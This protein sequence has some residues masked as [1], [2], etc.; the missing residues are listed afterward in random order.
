MFRLCTWL[1]VEDTTLDFKCT[2]RR[3]ELKYARYFAVYYDSIQILKTKQQIDQNR[4]V[5]SCCKYV[6][7]P[8]VYNSISE[9]FT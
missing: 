8:H 4:Y 9:Y 5:F 1:L 2:G 6:R 7:F 3:L